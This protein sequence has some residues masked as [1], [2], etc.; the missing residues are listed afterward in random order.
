MSV[1]QNKWEAVAV[2][3]NKEALQAGR[4]E[5]TAAFLKQF[6]MECLKEGNHKPTGNPNK[7]WKVQEVQEIHRD[8]ANMMAMG[9]L[10]DDSPV[11]EEL[12]EE[13]EN[14]EQDAGIDGAEAGHRQSEGDGNADGDNEDI[15]VQAAGE[16]ATTA[17]KAVAAESAMATANPTT[18]RAPRQ[19]LTPPKPPLLQRRRFVEEHQAYR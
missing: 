6:Y 15:E 1:G 8:I 18:P 17:E 14:E 13:E 16:K 12:E 7:P 19:Q 5:R 4:N 11:E 9:S 10:Q 2:K 3:Y